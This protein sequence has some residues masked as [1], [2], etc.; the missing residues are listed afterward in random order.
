M[1]QSRR[2]KAREIAIKHLSAGDALGWFEDLYLLADGD[3][4]IIPW[5]DLVPNPNLVSWL[6]ANKVNGKGRSALK[7]GCGL[8]DD[9]EE[10]ARRGFETTAFDI[11]KTAISWCRKRFPRSSVNYL[12]MDLF[13]TPQEWEQR[14]DF[15]L[16]SYTLQVLPPY[17][18]NEAARVISR[19]VRTGG[20]LLVIARG[21]DPGEDEGQ[22]P[23]PLL[24]SELDGF[25]KQGLREV[26]FENYMDREHP[27]VRR[28]RVLYEKQ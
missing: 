13:Q 26:M 21:R 14:F 7:I 5:A 20:Q 11:S 25:R 3:P 18:R 17:P 15:V 6:D 22:M 27:P 8:G 1:D 28:F 9:A 24:R 2:A 16:E 4:S 19:F 10:L 12:T 23:W